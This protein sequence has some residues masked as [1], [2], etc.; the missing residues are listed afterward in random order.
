MFVAFSTVASWV[1]GSYGLQEVGNEAI[2]EFCLTIITN[3]R[4]GLHHLLGHEGEQAS[5][6]ITSRLSLQSWFALGQKCATS[7]CFSL[8]SLGMGP[9]ILVWVT[10]IDL[11][12]GFSDKIG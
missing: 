2:K 7:I 5:T 10:G 1:F 4:L 8:S 3:F 9:Y 11:V 12:L 6:V